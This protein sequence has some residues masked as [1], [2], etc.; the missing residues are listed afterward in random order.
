MP[1]ISSPSADAIGAGGPEITPE[2][3]AAATAVLTADPYYG[4]C[5]GEGYAEHTARE[6]IERILQALSQQ[7]L[8]D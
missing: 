2:I 4:E 5:C 8:R 3:L 1:V 7:K 6:I